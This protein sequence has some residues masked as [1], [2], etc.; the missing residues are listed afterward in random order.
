MK[1]AAI[2]AE[3]NPFHNGHALQIKRIKEEHGFD[4]CVILM[5]GDFVQ[6]GAPALLGKY[7]RAEMALH[8]GADLVIELP[9][10]FV[11]S[12]AGE[13]AQAG[14]S[15]ANSLG[16][17]DC[18]AYS[19]ENPLFFASDR[20]SKLFPLLNTLSDEP[21]DFKEALMDRLKKGNSYPK[22]REE[23]LLSLHSFHAIKEDVLQILR[24]PNNLLALSYETAVRLFA[25][26]LQTLPL[27]REGSAHSAE[28]LGKSYPSAQAIRNALEEGKDPAE[29]SSFV[30]EKTLSILKEAAEDHRFLFA[31]DLTELLKYKL[32]FEGRYEI[33]QNV[34]ADLSAKLKNING[35]FNNISDLLL[36]LKSKDLT[37]TR[38]ARALFS[39][40]LE[41]KASDRETVPSHARI[42][43]FRKDASPLL[44]A[45]KQLSSVP[46]ISKDADAAELLRTELRASDV[47]RIIRE[48]KS[49]HPIKNDLEQPLVII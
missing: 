26:A 48:K 44:S 25:P 14:V 5:S 2:I 46:L 43:G 8:G 11:L 23:A 9:V 47:C 13:Y 31:D 7:E 36:A 16:A 38:L 22:A 28:A 4:Y 21:E 32:L 24:N 1:T 30:P 37:H 35:K 20:E 12:G 49:G 39:I 18:L 15:L 27:Q 42:L 34:T 6:R 17:V 29:L 41:L 3:Y 45:I 40:L 33:Y 10:S 19:C